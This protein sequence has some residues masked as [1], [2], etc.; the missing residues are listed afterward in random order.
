MTDVPLADPALYGLEDRATGSP[1]PTPCAPDCTYTCHERH[2]VHPAH[3]QFYCDQ[4]RAG[5]D[6]SEFEPEV[7]QRHE[8]DLRAARMLAERGLFGAVFGGTEGAELFG[9][10]PGHFRSRRP[11]WRARLLALL[12]S[13]SC[14]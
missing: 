2:R 13:W 9:G 6:V 14:G 1:C 8:A 12:R 3:D 4:I 11:P 7:R 10:D 5:R